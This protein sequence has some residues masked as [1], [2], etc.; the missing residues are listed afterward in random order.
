MSASKATVE[1][2][3]TDAFHLDEQEINTLFSVAAEIDDEDGEYWRF[4]NICEQE[5]LLRLPKERE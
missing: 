5:G 3:N 4:L 2:L 1:L